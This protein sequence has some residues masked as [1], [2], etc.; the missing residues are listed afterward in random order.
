MNYSQ[1][2]WR[3]MSMWS[4]VVLYFLCVLGLLCCSLVHHLTAIYNFSAF[5]ILVGFEL[6]GNSNPPS[7]D[8]LFFK[9][10]P[11]SFV[12]EDRIWIRGRAAAGGFGGE[13]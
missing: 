13:W 4:N 5:Q 1:E 2:V 12:P 11:A 9:K 3:K 10:N 7:F 6:N 8:F